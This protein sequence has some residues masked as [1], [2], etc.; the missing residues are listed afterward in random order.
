[1]S[2]TRPS[3]AGSRPTRSSASWSRRRT[4]SSR[5]TSPGR[6]AT[7][8]RSASASPPTASTPSGPSRRPDRHNLTPA[9]RPDGGTLALPMGELTTTTQ[10]GAIAIEFD[11][12]LYPKEAVYGAAYVF[13][14][15]CWVHLDRS[16]DRR[17]KVT[18]RPKPNVGLDPEAAA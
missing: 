9:S 3:A 17:I 1:G 10:D 14:D 2:S 12:T 5:A 4:S 13:I 6:P 16:A 11:E 15:R 18:L 7:R 8:S